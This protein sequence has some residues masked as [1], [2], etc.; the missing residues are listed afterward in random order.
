MTD[1]DIKKEIKQI[2]KL[3]LKRRAGSKER[4][5]LHRQIKELKTKLSS[6]VIDPKKKALIEELLKKDKLLSELEI[7]MNKFTIEQLEFHLKKLERK[8]DNS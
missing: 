1:K 5:D 3:K 2:K 7:D 6:V 8:N 4:I